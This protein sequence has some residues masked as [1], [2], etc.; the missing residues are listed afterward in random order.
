LSD[1]DRGD[2]LRAV[3]ALILHSPLVGPTTTRALAE[4]LADRGWTIN[5]PDLRESLDSPQTYAA[6][7]SQAAD[8]VGVLV[9]HSGAGAVLPV[10]AH[11]VNAKGTVFVDAIVPEAVARFTPSDG[12]LPLLD[13]LPV[14]DGAPAV[15]RV[16][17]GRSARPSRAR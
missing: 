17:T 13:Q 2:R 12:F 10:I 14:V 15:A 3:D 6:A 9:G 7:A 16:V 11:D 4:A 8:N 1:G 5:A